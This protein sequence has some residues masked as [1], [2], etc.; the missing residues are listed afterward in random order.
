MRSEELTWGD[1]RRSESVRRCLER[2]SELAD[3]GRLEE[4]V[5][6]IRGQI[7]HSPDCPVLNLS[8]GMLLADIGDYQGAYEA[9]KRELEITSRPR[10][11]AWRL[12]SACSQLGLVTESL[13][14]YELA[15]DVD[16]CCVP[17]LYGL[18]NASRRNNDYRGAIEYY[19]DAIFLHPELDRSD[20]FLSD[21]AAKKMA[22]N[23]Y[24]NLA[25]MHMI[26]REIQKAKELFKGVLRLWPTG[27]LAELADNYLN[28]LSQ[29]GALDS[30]KW[31]FYELPSQEA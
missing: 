10:D 30:I 21:I 16:P 25:V 3:E 22:V 18:G 5:E 13:R 12:G 28:L 2:S 14:A 27:Q 6:V 31:G 9:L 1:L 24:Y 7:S 8:L 15:L 11:A 4:A 19:E 26:L 20:P 29:D 17:A 23:V